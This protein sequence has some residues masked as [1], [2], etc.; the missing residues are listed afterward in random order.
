MLSFSRTP[1]ST[2]VG[3]TSVS[4]ESV[5]SWK[6]PSGTLVFGASAQSDSSEHA[7]RPAQS[8]S[9]KYLCN[10]R[11]SVSAKS[12]HGSQPSRKEG[13]QADVPFPWEA[14]HSCP[15]SSGSGPVWGRPSGRLALGSYGS[16]L[17]SGT[18][19]LGVWLS[20]LRPQFP[21]GRK[22]A[23]PGGKGSFSPRNALDPRLITSLPAASWFPAVYR[24]GRSS[25]AS[26]GVQKGPG[27]RS[28]AFFP[29]EARFDSP[30]GFK[31]GSPT[32]V[33]FTYGSWLAHF[34]PK[35]T[36]LSR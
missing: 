12:F 6:R 8:G 35:I 30:P 23:W 13:R 22:V 20:P 32:V 33:L 18:Q 7:Q 15:P 11:G 19:S 3:K 4:W 24:P 31:T 16:L 28:L 2:K 1:S 36:P 21:T 26:T 10:G 9:Q 25:H 27:P 34:I 5:R 14:F 29:S 17:S